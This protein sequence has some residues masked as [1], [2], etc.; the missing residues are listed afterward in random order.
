MISTENCYGSETIL[1]DTIVVDAT[2][3][4]F[5][6]SHRIHGRRNINELVDFG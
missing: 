2:H 4:K 5:V 1:H 6:R 3:Y